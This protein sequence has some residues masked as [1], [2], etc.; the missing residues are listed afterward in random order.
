MSKD[1]ELAVKTA[2]EA[3]KIVRENYD[4]KKLI[5]RKSVNEFVTD[6]DLKVEQF[7]E[8]QL[9]QTGYSFLGE[10]TG[11][12]K[13]AST[14][15]WVIDPIDGTCNFIRGNSFFAVSIALI[16][17]DHELLFGV[18]CDP[19]ANECYWA[20]KNKGAYMND[21]LIKTSE[22]AQLAPAI[23]LMEHG[24]SE[25]SKMD[26]LQCYKQ[27][28]LNEGPCML[29]QGSTALMLCHVAKGAFDA[30]LSC[31]DSL[32]DYAA[33]LIIA[34][35]AGAVISDWNGK[36]WNNSSSYILASNKPLKDLIIKRISGIQ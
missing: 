7:I 5:R 23:V 10:E 3:G 33:G 14:K 17:D 20:E 13:G 26:F 29:R 21:I 30:F 1:L 8:S 18:I 24:Y 28:T 16:N 35:E 34:E 36:P 12:K 19:M 22:E 11:E 27:L 9:A 15:K 32:Y 31:G 25:D 2:K 4:K 6:T